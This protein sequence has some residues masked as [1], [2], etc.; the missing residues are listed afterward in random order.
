VLAPLTDAGLTP[1]RGIKKLARAGVL[2]PGRNLGVLGIG[3]LGAYA[4]QYARLLGAGAT[5]VAFTRSDDKL[6]L[7]ARNGAKHTINTSNRSSDDIREE[8]ESLTGRRELDGVIDCAGAPRARPT[9]IVGRAV[10]VY[11]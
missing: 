10:I 9:R 7:A 4:V 6:E 11:A 1:Y 2:G 8:L 5:V 3:G